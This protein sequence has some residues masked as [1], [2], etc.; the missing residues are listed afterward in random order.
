MKAAVITAAFHNVVCQEEH[1]TI[2]VRARRNL[3]I[4]SHAAIAVGVVFLFTL[5]SGCATFQNSKEDEAQEQAEWHYEMGKGYFEANDTTHAIRELTQAIEIDADHS[6]AHY[7]LGFI[8]MGR[9]DYTR[10]IRHFRETLRI[11]PGYHFAK[12]NLGTVYLATERWEDAAELFQELL[13]ETLY[14]T[15]ELAH[16][17]LGWAYFKMG[18]HAE[19]LEHLRMA[20]FLSPEMCLADNNMAQVYEDMGNQTDA[21]RHYRR[22]IEKCPRNYQEPH[23]RLGKLLQSQGDRNAAAHFRRCIEIQSRSDMAERCRQYLS[24]N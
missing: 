3:G 5:L 20:V 19:A 18:R 23:F 24:A 17:N 10:A 21:A 13:D 1:D 4:W 15:P 11:D 6:T 16:N 12:N 8:Y 22:A 2:M 14:T 9:R 7:L